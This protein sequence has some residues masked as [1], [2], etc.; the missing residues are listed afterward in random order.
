M[1]K[2]GQS[3]PIKAR[4]HASHMEQMILAIFD[5]DKHIFTKMVKKWQCVNASFIVDTLAS[6][7][8]IL[9]KK[10]PQLVE[11]GWMFHWDNVPV[12]TAAVVQKWLSDHKVQA[13]DY[14]PY[15]P[16][17]SPAGYFLLTREKE[18]LSSPRLT[19]E[20]M[21]KTLDG[22]SHLSIKDEFAAAFRRW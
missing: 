8:K 6:F 5:A 10:R 13:L 4:V 11:Q 14:P 9:S 2:K 19:H 16:D 20:A 17:Q 1:D 22:V 12:H 15:L 3:G 7:L 18:L 21:N